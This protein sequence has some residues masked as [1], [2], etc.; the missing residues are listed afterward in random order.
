MS[1]GKGLEKEGLVENGQTGI[2]QWRWLDRTGLADGWDVREY[3]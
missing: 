1:G 2:H 3:G